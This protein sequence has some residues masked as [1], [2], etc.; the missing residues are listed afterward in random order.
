MFAAIAAAGFLIPG[1]ASQAL[2]VETEGTVVFDAGGFENDEA[3]NYPTQAAVGSYRFNQL[4]KVTVNTGKSADDRGPDAA[5]QGANYLTNDRER[6]G[7]IRAATFSQAIDPSKQSFSIKWSDWG[8]GGF[9][10]YSI[11]SNKADGTSGSTKNLLN[12]F[13][14]HSGGDGPNG[15]RFVSFNNSKRGGTKTLE[16]PYK[17]GQWNQ[18]HYAW[19]ASKKE[20][21]LTI[22]GESATL[23]SH[24][25]TLPA[26]VEQFFFRGNAPDSVIY[27]DALPE[28]E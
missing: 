15:T 8:H 12:S 24:S 17:F 18:M 4:S 19:D 13:G 7:A 22:N 3:G 10:A 1:P 27:I 16:L 14:V 21:T 6:G 28:S 25:A 26:K 2:V 5:T 9:T 23:T 20:A 11:G